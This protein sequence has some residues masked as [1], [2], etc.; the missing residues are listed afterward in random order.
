MDGKHF[1]GE[2]D[3]NHIHDRQKSREEVKQDQ[4]MLTLLISNYF[5]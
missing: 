5:E 4:N 3:D 2:Q 1:S